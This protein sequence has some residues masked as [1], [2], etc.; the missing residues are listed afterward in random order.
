MVENKEI[1]NVM[2]DYMVRAIAAHDQIRAFA[3]SDRDVVE[4]ARKDH[5]T[6]PVITAALGRTLSAGLM[7]GFMMDGD[8]DEITLQ[9]IGDGP[10]GGVTVTADPHGHAKGFVNNPHVDL[11]EK[12]N[13]HLDVGGAIGHGYLRV[14]KDM[15]LK[16]PYSG[17]INLV[18]GEVAEDLT[19][20]YAESE[21]VPSSVGLGVLVDTD[22][23]VKQAGG[24]IVQLMPGTDDETIDRLSDNIAHIDS[25]TDM[26]EKGYRPED[27]LKAVLD[28]FDVEFTEKQDVEFYCDC[29]HD[30]FAAKLKTLSQQDKNDLTSDGEPIE[31]VCRFCGKKYTF[32]PEEIL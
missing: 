5:D 24:F 13:G 20:Y 8:N 9:L 10:A 28:G 18:S 16:E 31:V 22:L 6:W 21:Q 15:G 3:I 14:I 29:S 30:K 11:P 1:I 32:T 23:T 27:I 25:V 12:S 26:L 4:T 19:Y 17:S 7:M 2:N